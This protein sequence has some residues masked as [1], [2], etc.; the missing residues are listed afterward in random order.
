MANI[1]AQLIKFIG[2]FF[3]NVVNFFIGIALLGKIIMS[4]KI[5]VRFS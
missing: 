4:K 1:A 5:K 2:L 3:I